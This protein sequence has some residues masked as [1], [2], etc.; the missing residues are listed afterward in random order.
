[1]KRKPNDYLRVDWTPWKR[2]PRYVDPVGLVEYYTGC[3]FMLLAFA[4]FVRLA[5]GWDRNNDRGWAPATLLMIGMIVFVLGLALLLLTGTS[6][7]LMRK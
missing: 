7:R 2:D 4:A 6:V 3:L 1:M 5:A